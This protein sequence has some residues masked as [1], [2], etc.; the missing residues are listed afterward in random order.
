M[1]NDG[2]MTLAE[3]KAEMNRVA[4]ANDDEWK[5]TVTVKEAGHALEVQEIADRHTLLYVEGDTLED[6]IRGAL[7]D[8]PDALA[9][10]GY[11]A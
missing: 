2:R 1:W 7:A 8:L 5:V 4:K 9:S 11:K 6:C 10:W 3:F